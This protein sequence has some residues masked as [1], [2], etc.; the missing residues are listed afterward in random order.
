MKTKDISAD[1]INV[2]TVFFPLSVKV[3][4]LRYGRQTVS[5]DV[6]TGVVLFD[7]K[8]GSFSI[9]RVSHERSKKNITVPIILSCLHIYY[10]I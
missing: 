3:K 9:E 6:D 1:F 10:V 7:K 4:M 8:S 5:V 2:L